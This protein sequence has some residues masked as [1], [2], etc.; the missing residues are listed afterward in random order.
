[1]NTKTDW[2]AYERQVAR[3]KPEMLKAMAELAAR[4]GVVTWDDDCDD[5][6]VSFLVE[7]PKPW[8][9]EDYKNRLDVKFSIWDSGD[10]DDGIYG[11]HGNFVLDIVEEGGRI[12]GGITPYNYSDDVWVDYSDDAEWD[13]RRQDIIRSLYDVAALVE[14]WL[15]E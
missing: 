14:R 9:G 4:F 13:Q 3:Q 12:V 1:M 6:N 11:Q 10:A 15:S 5:F 7:R 2:T 8:A